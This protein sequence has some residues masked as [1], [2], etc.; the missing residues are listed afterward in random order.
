MKTVKDKH[1]WI[2]GASSGIG[3]ALAK[4]LAAR[5]A[6][7]AVSARRKEA[8]ESLLTT[9]DGDGHI[10][11]P[12]DVTKH[13]DIKNAMTQI[14]TAFPSVDS[15]IDLAALYTPDDGTLQKLS[16]IHKVLDVNIG[17]IFN[18]IDVVRPFFE[19]QGYGQLV[20]CGSVAGYTGLTR[21]QPYSATKAAI[22]NL[23]QSLHVDLEPYQID[24]KLISPGF[25]D[26]PLTEKNT[27]KMPMIIDADEA[28]RAIANGVV[29]SRFEIHF[30]K[31]FTLCMKLLRMMPYWLY[32]RL[33]RKAR[34]SA[35]SDSV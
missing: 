28:A 6:V 17:G 20:L 7:L 15:V 33:M 14:K 29:Q 26:T 1:I 2:I 8:L 22:M 13:D 11:A 21:G 35:A 32:F 5:G 30:P 16:D 12:L 10:A 4:E 25:V 3:E 9:L 23:A 24:V 18:V 34:D 19:K 27:F 31:R